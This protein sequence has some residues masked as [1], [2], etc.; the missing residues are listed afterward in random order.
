MNGS[1]SVGYATSNGSATD[2]SDYSPA[3]GTVTFGPGETQKQITVPLIDNGHGT[4]DAGAQ[5][6]FNRTCSVS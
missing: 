6:S 1:V 2:R 4:A 3:S 5:R